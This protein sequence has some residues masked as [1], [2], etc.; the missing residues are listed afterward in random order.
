GG[1]A[2]A[3]PVRAWSGACG[4]EPSP[5]SSPAGPSWAE[6]RSGSE[7]SRA[8]G[9][10][11]LAVV[12]WPVAGCP[13]LCFPPPR[14]LSFPSPRPAPPPPPRPRPGPPPAPAG[15]GAP[16][17]R[18][19]IGTRSG[20]R[21]GLIEFGLVE[22]RR[23]E[24]LPPAPVRQRQPGGG[25]HV[26]GGD[27]GPPLPRR[28]REGRPRGH[29]VG[30]QPVHIERRAHRRDLAQRGIGQHHIGQ[31]PLRGDDPCGE[32]RFGLFPPPADPPPPRALA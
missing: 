12:S 26:H 24:R 31:Q 5:P 7:P 19:V 30:A 4:A 22:L 17:S 25:P 3:T 2:G 1:R 18:A 14:A 28:V 11:C 20:P 27:L 32:P 10:S 9:A 6:P 29:Q 15:P 21:Q 8:A 13:P 23:V 16:G